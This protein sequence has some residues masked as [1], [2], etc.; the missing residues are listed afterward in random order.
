MKPAPPVTRTLIPIPQVSV[1]CVCVRPYARPSPVATIAADIGDVKGAGGTSR[2]ASRLTVREP[3]LHGGMPA[4]DGG[5]AYRLPSPG[6][7]AAA[8]PGI[9]RHTTAVAHIASRRPAPAP[10]LHRGYAGTR[11][12]S[13]I[14]P[15]VARRPRRRSTGDM[16]AHDGGRAYRLP[17]PGARAAAPPGICR[18]TT[19]VARVASRRPRRRVRRA[20]PEVCPAPHPT[21]VSVGT[22]S[23]RSD[24]LGGP[25]RGLSTSSRSPTAPAS[26]PSHPA[27]LDRRAGGGSTAV[28][29]LHTRLP[30]RSVSRRADLGR[31]NGAGQRRDPAD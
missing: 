29:D 25:S 18:H 20:S 7:R 13:L 31:R 16:P 22:S 21:P 28:A 8:P 9:C 4:H 26:S 30:A 5:R 12:R 24:A 2:V 10:P 19:A 1:A 23:P 14:S 27:R 15:P 3:P 11:R 17:S 6:A